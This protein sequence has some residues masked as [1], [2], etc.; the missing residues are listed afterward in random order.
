MSHADDVRAYCERTYVAPAR[1]SGQNNVSIRAGDV[2]DAMRYRNRLPLVCA[3]LGA[4]L[5][6][7]QARVRRLG[8]DGPMNG[9]N[10][11]FRFE[12]LP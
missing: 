6:Q 11:V 7:D 4:S 5:F 8:I 12:V 10:T 3:A 2:H 1:A 9:A